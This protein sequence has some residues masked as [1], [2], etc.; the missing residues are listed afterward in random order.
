VIVS[1]SLPEG[2]VADLD[3]L[4]AKRGFG[5]RSEVVRV[6]LMEFV[7]AQRRE[8]QLAGHVNAIIVLGYP[9]K[10]ERAVTEVRHAHND[11]VTSMLHAHTVKERCT[12]VL[13]GEGP[14]EKM[15]RFLAELRGL[16]ELESIDVTILR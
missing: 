9:E 15:R 3:S 4:I 6:A 8:E 5:G 14:S 2:L 13:F 10:G 11:L 16:R 1:V 12:T 7:K